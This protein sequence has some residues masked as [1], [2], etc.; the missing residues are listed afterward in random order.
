M[1]ELL[2]TATS[3]DE[4]A[5]GASVAVLPVGSFE[6]HGDHL[7]LITDTVIANLIA[8]E[9]AETYPVFLL[10][11]ITFSCSHEH[12]GFPGTVSI[13]ATT[14][15]A[16]IAD[17]RESLAR[18]GINK[19]VIVNGHGGN[20]VLSN[21]AMQSNVDGR[22]VA[23]FPGRQDW[24]AARESAGMA[25]NAHDDMHGGELETALLLH[26]YP[27]LVRDSY[28]TADHQATHRPHLL[29]A[30]MAAYTESGIIGSP[31]QATASK[32]KAALDSL[33]KSFDGYMKMI[34]P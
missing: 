25:T 30:G 27:D 20:F 13:S 6:Q 31:S 24:D 9:I 7:P 19:L 16:I 28:R 26:A 10:P 8:A 12:E 5:R 17:I 21:I 4:A 18:S 11:P 34:S 15:T 14:L 1:P 23:L 2:T 3:T 22:H 29:L 32:G 33:V